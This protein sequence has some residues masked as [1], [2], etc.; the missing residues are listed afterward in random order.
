MPGVTSPRSWRVGVAALRTPLLASAI[1]AAFLGLAELAA[2]RSFVREAL[3]APSVGSPSRGFELQL[4]SLE[5]FAWTGPPVDCIVLGNSTALMGIDPDVLSDAYRSRTGRSL[6][7]FT[8]GVAGMTASAA[9]AVAPILVERFRPWL[10]VYVVSVRDVGRSVDGPLVARTPWV[11]YRLGTCSPEGWLAEHSAAFRYYLLYRQWFDGSRWRATS[12][13]AGTTRAGFLRAKSRLA[14][15]PELWDHTLRA[16][17]E[18]A[19]EPPSEP[20]FA[21]FSRVL[22]L[23]KDGTRILVVEAPANEKL[24]RWARRSTGFYDEA[25]RLLRREARDRHVDY[26]RVP[27]WRV[28]PGDGWFDFV[29]LNGVGA[30]GLSEWLGA[31]I[32]T[33]VGDDS[34]A[35]PREVAA[36]D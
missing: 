28:I 22:S 29:H 12:S 5:R 34:L 19:R 15:S 17:A 14:L 3:L 27:T 25:T 24:R 31:R 35:A 1:V 23:S 26:W 8:F 36:P 18:V 7:C 9:G 33:R 4:D 32:A 13:P 10:L 21:G 6:R 2:R 16:Y 11:Q 30:V 20:E